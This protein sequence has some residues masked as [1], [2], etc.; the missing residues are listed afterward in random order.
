MLCLGM[1]RDENA[2]MLVNAN[3]KEVQGWWEIYKEQTGY[4][5]EGNKGRM[6]TAEGCH[7][8]RP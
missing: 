1:E 8:S 2:E 7:S 4:E 3:V 6:E 5:H